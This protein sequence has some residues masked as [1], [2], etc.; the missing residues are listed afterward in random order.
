MK[1]TSVPINTEFSSSFFFKKKIINLLHRA[2]RQAMVDTKDLLKH[3]RNISRG[4]E[5][6]K[7]KKKKEGR[8]NT[9]M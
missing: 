5:K 2:C 7:K 9:E 3:G 4:K 1:Y 8:K 6:K